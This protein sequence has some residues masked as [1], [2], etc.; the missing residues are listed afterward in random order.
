MY[1]I[2]L[3]EIQYCRRNFLVSL[4]IFM[5]FVVYLNLIFSYN[6]TYKIKSLTVFFKALNNFV[7]YLLMSSLFIRLFNINLNNRFL[8]MSSNFFKFIAFQFY[9]RQR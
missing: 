2:Y 4:I 5:Y 1:I 6:L 9:L 3:L 7:M 8:N